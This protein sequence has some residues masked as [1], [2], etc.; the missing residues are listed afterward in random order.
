MSWWLGQ[1]RCQTRYVVVARP[2]AL[3]NALPIA[4]PLALPHALPLAL[5]LALPPPVD[6]NSRVRVGGP[7]GWAFCASVCAA[8]PYILVPVA[9]NPAQLLVMPPAET[10]PEAAPK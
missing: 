7:S 5:P 4:L 3:P 8:F 2:I 10:S 6:A 9:L 1:S